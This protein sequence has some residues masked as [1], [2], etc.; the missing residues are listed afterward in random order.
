[1]QVRF[2]HVTQRAEIIFADSDNLCLCPVIP[3]ELRKTVQNA[4]LKNTLKKT[5]WNSK[6]YSASHEKAKKEKKRSD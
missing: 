2:L 5:K 6:Q 3:R 4:I 1:M